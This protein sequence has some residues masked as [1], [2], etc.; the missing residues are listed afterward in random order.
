MQDK[1]FHNLIGPS[2]KPHPLP[3]DVSLIKDSKGVR[4]SEKI[5]VIGKAKRCKLI[6]I[7]KH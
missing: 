4:A 5:P 2:L 3:W 6:A 7:A 1:T